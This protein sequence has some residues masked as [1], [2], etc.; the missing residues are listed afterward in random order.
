MNQDNNRANIPLE[1]K[2]AYKWRFDV[3]KKIFAMIIS[4]TSKIKQQAMKI[5]TNMKN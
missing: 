4:K 3:L 2:K 1:S 5:R